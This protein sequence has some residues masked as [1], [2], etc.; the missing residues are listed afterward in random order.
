MTE[1]QNKVIYDYAIQS[2]EL[3][4]E[5]TYFIILHTL[6]SSNIIKFVDVFCINLY[7][8]QKKRKRKLKFK[9]LARNAGCEY[10]SWFSFLRIVLFTA[11]LPHS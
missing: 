1:I 6:I 4:F 5:F 7:L 8:K 2:D 9:I 3:L 11:L 10:F